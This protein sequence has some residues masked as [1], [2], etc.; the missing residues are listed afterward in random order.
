MVGEVRDLETAQICVRAALT[1]RFVLSTLH[2]MTLHL[3]LPVLW[4]SELNLSFNTFTLNGYRQQR[5][6]FAQI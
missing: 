6:G 4:I 2:T 5:E 1:S 3:Q